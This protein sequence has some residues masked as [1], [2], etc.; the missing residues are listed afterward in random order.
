MFSRHSVL[1]T[2]FVGALIV[3]FASIGL[4]QGEKK[5]PPKKLPV[6]VKAA[7]QK[8]YPAAKIKGASTEVEN[9]KIVYE[10]ESVDGKLSRDLLFSEDGTVIEIEES[11]PLK[12]L[13][14]DVSKTLKSETGKGKVQKAEKLTKGGTIQYEFVIRSGRD[15]REVI[16]DA[17]GKVV[18]T[19]MMKAQEKEE[20]KD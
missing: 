19:T 15:R 4:A 16:I 14:D 9:G 7:F 5:L 6:A 13:P 10:V 2:A 18:K 8:A 17:S 20:E 3:C 1:P 11:V 12:A